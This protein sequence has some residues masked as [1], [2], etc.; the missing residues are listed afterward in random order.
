MAVAISYVGTGTITTDGTSFN[1]GNFNAASAGV[2]V[3]V[4]CTMGGGGSQNPTMTIGGS[5]ATS[6]SV[7]VGSDGN[8]LSRIF[9]RAVS[10]GNQNVTADSTG[11]TLTAAFVAVYLLT[12]YQTEAPDQTRALTLTGT[13]VTI[14]LD[15]GPTGVAVYG[16]NHATPSDSI[17][18][19]SATTD[20][21]TSVDS[22]GRCSTAH[23]AASGAIGQAASWST[24]E[25]GN[26]V[27]VSAVWRDPPVASLRI[28]GQGGLAGVGGPLVGPGGLVG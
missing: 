4:L 5:S 20:T 24:S 22:T 15:Y 9:T 19:T 13:S 18:W 26:G 16:M 6:R 14:N 17:T 7:S 1:F 8:L 21:D 25:G 2:M 27:V 10:S 28:A 11:V 3:V 12:G 23:R